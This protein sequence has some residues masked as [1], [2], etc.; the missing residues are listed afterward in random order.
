M[1]RAKLQNEDLSGI[2]LPGINLSQA[3]L[4]G[5]NFSRAGLDEAKFA[6]ADLFGCRFPGSRAHTRGIYE[7]RFVR[8]PVPWRNR[9]GSDF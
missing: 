3:V 7:S 5:I 4:T 9:N 8:R 1:V 6:E 2:R